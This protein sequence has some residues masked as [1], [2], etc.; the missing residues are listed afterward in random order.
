MSA[1]LLHRAR[2]ELNEAMSEARYHE[3]VLELKL[4]RKAPL[5]GKKL[6]VM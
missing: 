1:T 5:G 3:G 2:R 6:P 4:V